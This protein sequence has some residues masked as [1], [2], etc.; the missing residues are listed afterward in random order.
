MKKL[1]QP[2]TIKFTGPD[3]TG[4]FLCICGNDPE[5]QGA[6]PCDS[7][8]RYIEPPPSI[9]PGNQFRCDRCGR[10]F[11]GL[12]GEVFGIADDSNEAELA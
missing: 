5:G 9:E 12:T 4:G 3:D 1:D 6:F 7:E 10:V 8:G 2:E 11:D